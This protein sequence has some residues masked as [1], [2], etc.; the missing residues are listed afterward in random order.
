M[1]LVRSFDN[2]VS[3]IT[4]PTNANLTPPHLCRF[5]DIDITLM[6]FMGLGH[7]TYLGAKVANAGQPTL[8]KSAAAASAASSTGYTRR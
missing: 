6:V 7:A 2:L 8:T 5:S 4:C 3:V 1:Y